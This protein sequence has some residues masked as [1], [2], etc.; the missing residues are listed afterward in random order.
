MEVGFWVATRL[1]LLAR[2]PDQCGGAR[3]GPKTTS[4]DL[5]NVC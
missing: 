1:L 5:Q 2:D 4:C 3:E